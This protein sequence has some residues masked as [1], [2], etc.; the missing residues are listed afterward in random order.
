MTELSKTKVQAQYKRVI[1]AFHDLSDCRQYLNRLLGRNGETPPAPADRVQREAL[2]TA[3]VVSYTR[4]FS[5]NRSA[6]DVAPRIPRTFQ[7]SLSPAQVALH[8]RMLRLRNGEFAHSDPDVSQVKVTVS[9]APGMR[10][11]AM[12][13]SNIPRQGLSPADLETLDTVC[14]ALHTYLYDEMLKLQQHLEPGETF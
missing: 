12:P 13:V 8:K 5:G 2:M 7:R 11:I 6:A 4:S 1:I 9:T 3:I 14:A 10:G